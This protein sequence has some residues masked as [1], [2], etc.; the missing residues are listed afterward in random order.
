M[1]ATLF[2]DIVPHYHLE[3]RVEVKTAQGVWRLARVTMIRTQVDEIGVTYC[4]GSSNSEH[5]T[6]LTGSSIRALTTH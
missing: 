5:V 3:E 6:S 4:D 1:P 2:G